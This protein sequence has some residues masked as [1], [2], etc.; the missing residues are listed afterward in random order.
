MC[1]LLGADMCWI[2]CCICT[3]DVDLIKIGEIYTEHTVIVLWMVADI[4]TACMF[5]F[6]VISL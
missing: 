4:A 2:Y 6:S 5:V 1:L 3:T